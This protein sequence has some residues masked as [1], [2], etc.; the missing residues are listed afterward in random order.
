MNR[1]PACCEAGPGEDCAAPYC[2]CEVGREQTRRIELSQEVTTAQAPVQGEIVTPDM[3]DAL[4]LEARFKRGFREQVE[5][6]AEIKHR[7]LWRSF[8]FQHFMDYC[9]AR[10]DLQKSRVYQLLD[11]AEVFGLL[12]ARN[13]TVVE[14]L[15]NENQVRPLAGMKSVASK[16][17]VLEAA[18][19]VAEEHG[20]KIT[21]KLVESVARDKFDWTPR[22]EYRRQQA[23][24]RAKR[25]LERRQFVDK[26]N[27]RVE[28]LVE[29]GPPAELVEA[30]GSAFEWEWFRKLKDWVDDLAEGS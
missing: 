23:D 19:K 2:L 4:A 8:G 28:A 5:S 24:A 22:A 13:S 10:L 9:R 11:A 21:G 17:R 14:S 1:R 18:A 7:E 16:V 27:R 30:Y 12:A 20:G 26:F 6:L 3:E 29:L 15:T 25:K